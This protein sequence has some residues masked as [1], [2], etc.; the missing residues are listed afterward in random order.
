MPHRFSVFLAALYQLRFSVKISQIFSGD[1]G[2][3]T[4]QD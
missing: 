2:G 3:G 1:S 4:V